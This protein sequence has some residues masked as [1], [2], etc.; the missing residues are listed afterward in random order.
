MRKNVFGRKFKR[1]ANERKALFKSLMSELVLHGR[2]KTTEQK[3]K[4]IKASAEKLITKARKDTLLAKK[5]LS[6][7]LV[8]EAIEKVMSD[9]TPKFA[10]RNGGYTRIIRMGRRF[11]DDASMVLLEWVEGVGQVVKG[12]K[13]E[14]TIVPK[15][16]KAPRKSQKQEVVEGEIVVG[17]KASEEKKQSKQNAKRDKKTVTKKKPK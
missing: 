7:E 11:N 13:K 8:P 6:M 14:M 2:I 5:L 1:D 12:E 3:A 4:S 15:K 17:E 10:G 16:E 9:I